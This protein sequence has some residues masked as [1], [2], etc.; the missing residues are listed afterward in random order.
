MLIVELIIR[1]H[2]WLGVIKSND[3][4]GEFTYNDKKQRSISISQSPGRILQQHARLCRPHR[5]NGPNRETAWVAD[6]RACSRPGSGSS[7]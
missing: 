3:N 4:S 2:I 7:R 5:H 1:F 6:C